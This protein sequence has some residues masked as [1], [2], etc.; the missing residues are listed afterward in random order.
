MPPSSGWKSK[1]SNSK[2]SKLRISC[3]SYCFGLLY[4]E[5]GGITFLGNAELLTGPLLITTPKKPSVTI[6]NPTS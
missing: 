1:P 2:E 6:L 5:D 3:C 4:P